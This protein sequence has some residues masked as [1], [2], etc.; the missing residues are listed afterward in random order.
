MGRWI[1]AHHQIPLVDYW[2]MSGA[3]N[4]WRAYSWSNEII[5]AAIDKAYG[6]RGLYIAQFVLAC[7]FTLALSL[8]FGKLAS[9]FYFGA[10]IAA[11]VACGCSDHFALRPQS[12]TWIYFICVIFLGA[13]IAEGRLTRQKVLALFFLMMLW[14]NTHITTSLGLV[15]VL[16]WGINWEGTEAKTGLICKLLLVSIC[17]ILATPYL[18]G[19]LLTFASKVTHPFQHIS[20]TEFQPANLQQYPTGVLLFLSVLLAALLHIRPKS[21]PAVKLLCAAGFTL[22]GLAVIKFLPQALIVVGALLCEVWANSKRIKNQ[23]PGLFEAIS[24]LESL[25]TQ[26][27]SMILVPLCFALGAG[28]FYKIYRAP[29]DRNRTPVLPVDF[30]QE[31][32]LPL[33]VLGIFDHGGYLMYRFSNDRG[34]PEFLVAIDGRTN[35]TSPEIFKK[36]RAAVT[37]LVNWRDFIEAADPKTILWHNIAP[38]T[39]ILENGS[40][41]CEVYQDGD[42]LTGYSVFVKNDL[43]REFAAELPSKNCSVKAN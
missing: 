26:R 34:E 17:G 41:W 19:E 6:V 24:R 9:D 29:L 39:A 21:L 31:K 15:I 43:Y 12:L 38:L 42:R 4:P 11:L 2:N 20:V 3:G 40:D 10:I 14:A 30:I 1:L 23:G 28:N 5:F 22:G 16:I 27:L 36:H 35:V 13:R 7:A 32:K 33:P 25:F 18:G 37:G 8:V